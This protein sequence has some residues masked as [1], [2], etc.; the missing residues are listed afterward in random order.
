ML[1][2]TKAITT[3]A[4]SPAVIPSHVA[5]PTAISAMLKIHNSRSTTSAF[6]RCARGGT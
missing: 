1:I 3:L 6:L 5:T 2:V 4:A